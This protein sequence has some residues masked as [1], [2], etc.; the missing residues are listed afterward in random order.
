MASVPGISRPF[1]CSREGE[2]ACIVVGSGRHQPHLPAVALES[3]ARN[4]VDD[5]PDRVAVA[6]RRHRLDHLDV[7][8]AGSCF[9]LVDRERLAADR[10]RHGEGL[11]LEGRA[12]QG[13]VER[14]GA[15]GDDGG[16]ARG[17][18]EADILNLQAAIPGRQARQ[19]V[20]AV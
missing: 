13:N 15:A 14:R 6:V 1:R 19:T 17:E 9:L 20:A 18:V 7:G 4:D 11:H 5:F 12:L 16:V 2:A 3:R 8:D 10:L